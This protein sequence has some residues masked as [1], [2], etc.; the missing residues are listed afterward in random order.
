MS[1]SFVR[2][3]ILNYFASDITTETNVLDV[4]AKFDFLLDFL[5]DNGVTAKDRWLGL[6]FVGAEEQPISVP[7]NNSQ[8]RYRE[9]GSIFVHIVEVARS[10][11]DVQLI[12]RSENIRQKLRGLNLNGVRIESVSPPNFEFGATLNF[13]GGYT[14][15]A[16]IVNYEYDINI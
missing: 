13:D 2:T 16:I 7:A 1:S 6:Q 3:Q 14:A 8:G 4:T 12:T 10:N 15:C 5:N 11:S 9:F